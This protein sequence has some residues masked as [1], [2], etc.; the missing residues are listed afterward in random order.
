M[1]NFSKENHE[2]INAVTR[3]ALGRVFIQRN[4]HCKRSILGSQIEFGLTTTNEAQRSTQYDR[5]QQSGILG[6]RYPSKDEQKSSPF[7][8]M[9]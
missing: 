9:M 6:D 5:V 1:N 8:A 2:T 3:P 4:Q 7:A